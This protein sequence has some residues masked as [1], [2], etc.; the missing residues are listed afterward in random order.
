MLGE[1]ENVEPP[2]DLVKSMM[3]MAD[4]DGDGKVNFI[5]FCKV[6]DPEF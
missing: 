1:I 6:V 5:E 2:K 3:E 4:L